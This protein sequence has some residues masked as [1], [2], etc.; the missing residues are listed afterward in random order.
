MRYF[1]A[2]YASK[3]N[4]SYDEAVKVERKLKNNDLAT[5]SVIMDFKERKV[6]KLRLEDG[7]VGDKNWNR[8]WLYYHQHYKDLVEM[9]DKENGYVEELQSLPV[10]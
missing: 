1:I 4:G 6:I 8:V 7:T 2:T 3:P 10:Q 9:L 5:A